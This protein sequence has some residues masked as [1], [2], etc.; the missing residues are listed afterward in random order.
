MKR[1]SKALKNFFFP[2]DNASILIRVLP[3]FTMVLVFV[4]LFAIGNYTWEATSTVTFCG[5]TCHTMPPEYVTHQHSAHA[6]VACED[7][8]MGRDSF[9]V[10]LGRKIAYSWQTGTAMLTN[11][12]VYPIVAK[13]M[14]PAR[15]ACENCHKPETFTSDKLVEIK[16][17][18]PD[19][20]NTPSSIFLSLKIGGG[21]RRQGLGLGIHWHVEN[22]V[23]FY[24]EDKERQKIPYVVV[25]NADGTTTEYLD[26]DSGVIPARIPKDQ[27]QKMDCITCHNRTAHG[28]TD[29]ENT[30]DQLIDR[31]LISKEIP[32]IKKKAVEAINATYPSV[33]EATDA[34]AG[35]DKFYQD[36]YADFYAKNKDLVTK[37]ISAL[38]TA[39]ED[40]NFPDQKFDWQTHPNNI[41]H[42][43]TAGCFRCHD[44]KHLS[45]S[46]QSIR[47]ECNLCHTI[48][49]VSGPTQI[50]AVLQLNRGFEPESHQNANWILLHR[51]VFDDSCQGCHTVEDAGGVSN[52][53]FCSNS[54]CH[55]AKWTFA[56]FDAPKL[57]EVIADQARAMITPTAIPTATPV[58]APTPNAET[59]AT[60]DGGIRAILVDKC[61]KCHGENAMKG[62]NLT[63][64]ASL[65]K[66]G[67]DGPAIVKGD[68]TNSLLV[69]IQ[70][71]SQPHFG[72]LAPDQL[73]QIMRWIQAGAP[74]K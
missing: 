41:G 55:G 24:A 20:Q 34:I 36:S 4:V 6:N 26:T 66:G 37:A 10:M 39:Y 29:P 32:E 11:S 22:P 51:T 54:A 70:T 40:A 64:Y 44:G 46:G 30:V 48:P 14:R 27:L 56:G 38:Q 43:D 42:T 9:R 1:I 19:E 65:L 3:V 8:H 72:Q 63:T 13:N 49:V 67:E 59:A 50:N 33:Q 16:H 23:Y 31:D 7:C 25:S 61:G 45:P 52:T 35:L 18:A 12:Y 21:T 60:Y 69:K 58:G 17:F 62:L 71:G 28:L 53:S 5:T 57:R 74:E 2:P 15:D 73:A 68:P 47:L